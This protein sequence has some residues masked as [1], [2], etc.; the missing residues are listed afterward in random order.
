MGKFD[1]L[2]DAYK[3]AKGKSSLIPSETP[4]GQLSMLTHGYGSVPKAKPA[5]SRAVHAAVMRGIRGAATPPFSPTGKVSGSTGTAK[6][7]VKLAARTQ[8]REQQRRM[9]QAADARSASRGRAYAKVQSDMMEGNINAST[10]VS[11]NKDI[12][13]A[14]AAITQQDKMDVARSAGQM[15]GR[16]WKRQ[17]SILMARRRR[18]GI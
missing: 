10:A 2:S 14:D 9:R 16:E 11:R 7:R 13:A 4:E 8:E 18:A 3:F 6:S 17:N 5:S 1:I 15:T 12:A